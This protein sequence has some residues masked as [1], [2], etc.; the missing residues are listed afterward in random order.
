M[1]S[2]TDP[3]EIPVQAAPHPY[4]RLVA[5]RLVVVLGLTLL[6]CL[7]VAVDV[8][9]GPARY[10]LADV[11]RTLLLPKVAPMQMQVVIWDIRLPM[12]LM[13]VTV[14]AACRLPGRRC[15]RSLPIRWPALLPLASLPRQASGRRW[16][17]CWASRSFLPRWR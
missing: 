3:A 16:R 7:S 13:A 1:T 17:W 12:A 8:S 5:R 9:L 4:H 14:G 15:R 6:L 10:P 11:A 2:L